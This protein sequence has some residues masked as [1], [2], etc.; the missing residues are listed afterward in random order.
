MRTLQ[1]IV[2]SLVCMVSGVMA[3][4]LINSVGMKFVSIKG[5]EYMMGYQPRDVNGC[6]KDDPFTKKREGGEC[7]FKILRKNEEYKYSAPYHKEA[8]EDFYMG[9]TEVTQLQYYKVM[10]KNPSFFQTDKLKYDSRNNPVEDISFKKARS[11]VKQLNA[12]E[13]TTK[14]RLPTRAEW[15][16]VAHTGSPSRWSFGND[17]R[18]LQEYAWYRKNSARKTHPVAEKNPN[19][20]GV[21]DIYGNVTE[22]VK[23]AKSGGAVGGGFHS[24]IDDVSPYWYHVKWTAQRS[25]YNISKRYNGLRVVR[26]K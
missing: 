4:E 24:S 18:A 5:G 2:I 6:P 12:L 25:G 10:G 20:F 17:A 13:K 22:Y 16:Y 11:F 14:Y 15:E 23:D 9:V 7:Y 19:A 26:D 3:E 8:V 1:N 21:Y